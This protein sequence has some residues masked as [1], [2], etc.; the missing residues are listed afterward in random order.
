VRILVGGMIGDVPRQGGATWAVLQYVLGLRQLGH[1]VV[2]VEQVERLDDSRPYFDEV[3]RSFGLTAT[4]IERGTG[5][6]HGLPDRELRSGADLL[7]NLSGLLDD[8]ELLRSADSRVFVDLDPAF[9]QL[10]FEADG[11]DPGFDRHDRFVTV[12]AALGTPAC[13]V[14]TCG[15]TW[16]S[17]PQPIVLSHWPVATSLRH[18]A[19]TTVGH[20][21]GYGSIV[22]GNV[23]YGQRAHSMRRLLGLAKRSGS[24]FLLALA[25]DPE[26]R[27]DLDALNVHG[28][29][30]VDPASV[31]GTPSDF[32][33][34]VQGS[35]A[36]LGIAKLG[37]VVSRC[38]WFS[39]RS[40][41][42]L[43]SGRPVVAQETG[44]SEWLPA[45]EG[46]FAYSTT[47]EAAA[48][49]DEVA[50]DYPRHR[51]AARELAEDVFASDRVLGRLLACL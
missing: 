43:A 1:D 49:F 31:A 12:G 23:H 9:T 19:A 4:L 40:V 7:L 45:G 41:C 15:L 30:L 14:P 29:K 36:E 13:T 38:G 47:D 6:T 27:G 17:T 37:Y 22:H 11:I 5:R 28:W 33:V 8:E 50:R 35:W 46:L 32:R 26:E 3:V 39:D 2:F 20:W 25:I 44:F 48:A 16:I 51:R 42:Y 24:R 10:W 34:F 21:R 18:E